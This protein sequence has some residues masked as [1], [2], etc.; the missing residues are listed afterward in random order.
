MFLV[1]RMVHGDVF[2]NDRRM[3]VLRM[4]RGQA[5]WSR[6]VGFSMRELF[7]DPSCDRCRRKPYDHF[8]YESS[9]DAEDMGNQV[10]AP[11]LYFLK[12]GFWSGLQH[13]QHFEE[14]LHVPRRRLLPG[15]IGSPVWRRGQILHSR[16]KSSRP[17][18]N[19]KDFF[20]SACCL[21]QRR[22]LSCEFKGLHRLPHRA[23]LKEN[24]KFAFDA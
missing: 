10:F 22:K 23:I 17:S 11:R 19:V 18:R 12:E 2:V 1:D 24:F 16:C 13:I 15:L 9:Y 4:G 14:R 21:T 20:R 5:L 7:Q 3:R 6:D 8:S